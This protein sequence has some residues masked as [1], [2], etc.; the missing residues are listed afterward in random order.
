MTCQDLAWNAKERQKRGCSKNSWRGDAEMLSLKIKN[1]SLERIRK[2][3]LVLRREE[4][5]E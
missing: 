4:K 3:D 2:D 1:P 5:G